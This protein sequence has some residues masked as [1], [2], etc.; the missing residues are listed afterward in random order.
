MSKI[1]RMTTKYMNSSALLWVSHLI[2]N[3]VHYMKP[4][5]VV[6][7]AE[8]IKASINKRHF[9]VGIFLNT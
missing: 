5:I 9:G 6:K 2:Q 1:E 8:Y 3:P 4:E 7:V